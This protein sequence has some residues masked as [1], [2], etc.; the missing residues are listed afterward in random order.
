MCIYVEVPMI[1]HTHTDSY[2]RVPLSLQLQPPS[3]SC[4]SPKSAIL[5]TSTQFHGVSVCDARGNAPSCNVE[6]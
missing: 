1:V 2:I 3:L 5:V 6:I 4:L